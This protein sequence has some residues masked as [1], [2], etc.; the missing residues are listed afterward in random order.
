M[1]VKK[2][3][4]NQ[5]ELTYNRASDIYDV[6]A[7]NSG[8]TF[9][10]LSALLSAE[11]LYTLIPTALRCG[12]MTIR[13]I[14]SSDNKYVQYMLMSD[15]FN[16]TPTNWR[17]VYEEV[18]QLGQEVF[19]N[20]TQIGESMNYNLSVHYGKIIG[21]DGAIYYEETR[22]TFVIP[23][24][25]ANTISSI[26]GCGAITAISLYTSKPNFIDATGFVERL[27]QPSFPLS[28]ESSIKYAI[29]DF[30]TENLST[31]LL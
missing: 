22:S 14:Q 3:N 25:G 2:I 16:T 11:N 26:N 7:N 19:D 28:I 18:C 12:G 29:V 9:E 24:M 31:I 6:T 1:D 5:S 4:I 10:S 27:L 8:A 15:T 13:F 20:Q 30:K 21:Q 17:G 23:L